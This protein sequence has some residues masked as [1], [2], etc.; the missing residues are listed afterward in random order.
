MS[1]NSREALKRQEHMALQKIKFQTNIPVEM[2]LKFAEGKLCDSQFGDPQFMFTTVDDQVFFVA[3]K[4][5]QKIHGLR[6]KA[7]EPLEIIKAEK[8]YGNGRKGIEW[9][10]NRVG[11]T[12]GEQPDGTF[13]VPVVN[14]TAVSPAAPPKAPTKVQQQQP[15]ANGNGNNNSH[16]NGNGQAAPPALP[17]EAPQ[18]LTQWAVSLLGQTKQVIDVYAMACE[19]ASKAHGNTVRTDDVRAIMTTAFINLS[20]QGGANV[21]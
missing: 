11:F 17:L 18:P 10:V 5:A 20:K 19:Y 8:D 6:L 16:T 21:A 4:V 1:Y 7:Q 14:G 13:S 9:L 3:E 12:P 15:V 2:A